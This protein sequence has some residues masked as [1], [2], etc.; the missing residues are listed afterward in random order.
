MA[1]AAVPKKTA[2]VLLRHKFPPAPQLLSLQQL[3]Q[4]KQAASSSLSAAVTGSDSL[5]DGG[6]VKKQ[7]AQEAASADAAGVDAALYAS[8]RE[9]Q[10]QGVAF[11]LQRHGRVLIGDEMGLGKTIQALTIAAHYMEDWPLLVVCPSS[12]RF[13]WRDQ[14]L[15]WLGHILTPEQVADVLTSHKICIIR[16]GK[17]E[18]SSQTRVVII[19]YDLLAKQERFQANYQASLRLFLTYTRTEGLCCGSCSA[20]AINQ[21]LKRHAIHHPPPPLPLLLTPL[22][23]VMALVSVSLSLLMQC[24]ICDES[25]YLKNHHAKRTQMICPMLRH[26]RRALLLSGTPA[27]NRPVELYQQLNSLLPDLCSYREFSDRYCLPVFNAF[28]K[29]LEDEGHQ[30]EEELHLLLKHTVLIRR[31]KKDVLTELPP[32]LRSRIPIEIS[33]KDL[34]EI[35]RKLA[36]CDVSTLVPKE[37]DEAAGAGTTDAGAALSKD[38]VAVL[39][40]TACGQGLDLTAAGTVVFAELYW[41]PGFILQAEDRSHRIGNQHRSVQI[42][43]LIGENTIDDAVY[44]L[45]Q[46]KWGV[47]TSTLDGQQQQLSIETC[48]KHAMP[49]LARSGLPEKGQEETHA[50]AEEDDSIEPVQEGGSR[51]KRLPAC[52]RSPSR[53]L[54]R[55]QRLRGDPIPPAD[56]VVVLA[57]AVFAAVASNGEIPASQGTLRLEGLP[58][59]QAVSAPLGDPTDRQVTTY[60]ALHK[61]LSE[62]STEGE[63]YG[64]RLKGLKAAAVRRTDSVYVETSEGPQSSGFERAPGLRLPRGSSAALLGTEGHAEGPLGGPS[65]AGGTA[66]Q[67]TEGRLAA[68]VVVVVVGSQQQMKR[69]KKGLT[70][71]GN[72]T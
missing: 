56:R 15:R 60:I 9:F 49:S 30:H 57:A 47:L 17:T 40:I 43:Y 20:H 31:L 45:L 2:L 24:V 12:I 66:Q 29:R 50:A 69:Q 8:L 16:N 5:A 59:T 54:G 27:L 33:P 39:S 21:L 44:R 14:A 26:A 46:T 42:H 37:S 72:F 3:Q 61:S 36:G 68:W 65:S 23:F 22:F 58:T 63:R 1:A 35:R 4:A 71:L 28:T 52:S 55:P 67:L 38:S 41:V 62:S 6:A 11:G 19:S 70:S 13:Q 32:K 10:R 64:V 51:L 25:H 18:I 48:S 53:S 34:K 7:A